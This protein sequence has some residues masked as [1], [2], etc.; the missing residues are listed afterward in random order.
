MFKGVT[1]T[2]KWVSYVPIKRNLRANRR[3]TDF[4]IVADGASQQPCWTDND[5][6][7][8]DRT[9]PSVHLHSWHRSC[10]ITTHAH[11][12]AAG[13]TPTQVGLF[14]VI[15]VAQ[16]TNIRE[17]TDRFILD[18]GYTNVILGIAN[19]ISIE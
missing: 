10:A 19:I 17:L 9:E 3:D 16:L 18:L 7:L 8:F 6:K 13:S 14:V 15:A 5:D 12:W 1:R 2:S 4:R 11:F